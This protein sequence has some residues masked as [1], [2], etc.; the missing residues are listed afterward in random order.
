MLPKSNFDCFKMHK[1]CKAICCSDSTPIPLDTFHKYKD[2]I[3]NYPLRTTVIPPDHISGETDTGRCM[4]LNDDHTCN[5]YEDRPE[6]CKKFGDE[7]HPMLTC[8]FQAKCGRI[9]SRQEKRRIEREMNR[10]IE[11]FHEKMSKE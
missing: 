8:G 4:F 7:S 6:I 10:W 9:R 5:I 2:K 11:I 1:K 3:V